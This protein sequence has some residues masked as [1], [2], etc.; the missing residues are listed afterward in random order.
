[1][2][3]FLTILLGCLSPVLVFL[4]VIFGVLIIAEGK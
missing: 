3:H 2:E 4:A 1:M